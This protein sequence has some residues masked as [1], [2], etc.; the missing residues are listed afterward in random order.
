MGTN[1][2]NSKEVVLL[3][4]LSVDQ[5]FIQM[6][7]LKW[8]VK[9]ADPL[10]YH[11]PNA[12]ILNETAIE[13]LD[14]DADPVNKKMDNELVVAG[15]LEDF[16]YASLQ[17]KIDAL[18]LFVTQDNDTTSLWAKNGGCL[19]VSINPRVN[20]PGFISQ[21]KTVYEKYDSESPFSYHFLDDAF[22]S[23]YKA[24]NR[25][26]KILT[27]FTAFIIFIASL[28]LFGLAAFMV[29]H[30]TKEVG[31]R[32]VLGAS[33]TQLSLMLSKDFAK[34]VIV[35]IIIASPV[36]WWIM[37]KWLE[38]FA[39]RINISWWIFLVA[40]IIALLVA[41]MTVGFQAIKAAIANPVKSLRTE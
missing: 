22:D 20:I 1:P 7:G 36:A 34:L 2:V 33:A 18:C 25:L 15:I 6:L 30:R 17:N 35:S 27:A 24:E 12:A 26:F 14:L 32:K 3:P 29:V 37:N 13:K 5:H 21:A 8:K 39:Y 28:G 16:N 38:G 40:G 10:F 31:I 4:T 19:F 11:N 41:W 9:P 23:L